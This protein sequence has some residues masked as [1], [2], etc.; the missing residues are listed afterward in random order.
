[1][2]AVPCTTYYA[3]TTD[4]NWPGGQLLS[5]WRKNLGLIG[6]VSLQST[7]QRVLVLLLL[8]PLKAGCGQSSVAFTLVLYAEKSSTGFSPQSGNILWRTGP[9]GLLSNTRIKAALACDRLPQIA[10]QLAR[11]GPLKC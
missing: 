2:C 4:L 11:I 9:K 5:R 10:R 6:L 8:I 1:M 7:L 3:L